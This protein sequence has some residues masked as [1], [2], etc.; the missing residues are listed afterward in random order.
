MYSNLWD[1]MK[2]VIRGKFIVPSAYI[3]NLE[4]S[5]TSKVITYLKALE[6]KEANTPKRNSGRK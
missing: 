4:K 1:T 6:R 5:H 2:V 3:K